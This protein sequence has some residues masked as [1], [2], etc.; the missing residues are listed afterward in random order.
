VG[1]LLSHVGR[2]SAKHYSSH[3]KERTKSFP[4]I[5]YRR[6]AH[7]VILAVCSVH[8]DGGVPLVFMVPAHHVHTCKSKHR[9]CKSK[10]FRRQWMITHDPQNEPGSHASA[11]EQGSRNATGFL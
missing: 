6:N 3:P 7:Y 4:A 2:T 5:S 9:T 10:V 1:R 11:V 8:G